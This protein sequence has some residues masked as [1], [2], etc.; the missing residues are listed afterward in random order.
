V[1]VLADEIHEFKNNHSIETWKRAIAKMPGDAL[2]LLGTNTPASTQLVGTEYSEFYQAVLS[3]KVKDDEAFAFIARVDK[4]DHD[5]VFE[6]ENCWK[7]ALPA[8]GITFPIENIRGE[9]NTAKQ[10]ASTALSVKRLYFGIPTGVDEFWMD[11]EQAWLDVQG[12]V[13]P[14]KL[15]GRR[16][17]LSL[18]LSKKNDLT[19][20]SAAWEPDPDN[21]D[22]ALRPLQVKTWYWTTKKGLRTGR[23][24]TSR[25]MS[26][27]RK[28]QRSTS[29][30][31]TDR[32]STRRSQPRKSQ[33]SPPST[34]CSFSRLTR[35][36]WPI[37]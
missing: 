22:E 18:D 35:L 14:Q 5:R 6:N 3:G 37:L 24:A 25:R 8:L 13:D 19:A 9:V 17:W 23:A 27:G 2:M 20:L 11:D 15:K 21:E 32:R 16:C 4:K 33:R 1:A 26:N 29:P 28:I 31:S 7:K 34:M 10:L 30:P 36:A 12:R